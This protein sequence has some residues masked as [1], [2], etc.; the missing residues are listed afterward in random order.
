MC[1]GF[2]AEI[3]RPTRPCRATQPCEN[4]AGWAANSTATFTSPKPHSARS[5]LTIAATETDLGVNFKLDFSD[6]YKVRWVRGN[7]LENVGSGAAF[8]YLL[9]TQAAMSED[10]LKPPSSHP[11]FSRQGIKPCLFLKTFRFMFPKK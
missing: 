9:S 6:C 1:N 3:A 7:V 10:S 5:A 8:S 2:W 4:T 11:D